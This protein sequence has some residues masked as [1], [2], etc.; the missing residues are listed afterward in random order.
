M[1]VS[2][3][4]TVNSR[5]IQVSPNRNMNPASNASNLQVSL[6]DMENF[7]CILLNLGDTFNLITTK[8]D[9]MKIQALKSMMRII[10][11]RN[12]P[13]NTPISL[14]KQLCKIYSIKLQIVNFMQNSQSSSCVKLCDI[15][16]R[17]DTYRYYH[18]KQR[19]SC[20]IKC[21]N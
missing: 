2:A 10:G 8:L 1:L 20:V 4:T 14:M 5:I 17:I 19:A 11:T 7:C 15:V 16:V 21:S 3:P 9:A 18:R 13:K 6:D 12:A